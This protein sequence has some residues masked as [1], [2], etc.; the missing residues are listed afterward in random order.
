MEEITQIAAR[1]KLAIIEDNAQAIG[2]TYTFPN[3]VTKKTGAIGTIGTT[4]F[5]PSKNLG[6]YGDGGAIFT[7]D[8]ALASRLKMIA[9]HGQSR[10][11]YHYLVGCNS[12]LHSIPPAVFHLKL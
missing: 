2:S 11:Y 9:N 3:G 12:R 4:S 1:H 6:C 5:F 8:D 7:D 10:L